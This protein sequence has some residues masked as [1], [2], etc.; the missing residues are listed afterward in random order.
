MTEREG[1]GGKGGS[2]G[3]RR[4]DEGK[5]AKDENVVGEEEAQQ[6]EGKNASIVGEKGG[7]R[8]DYCGEERACR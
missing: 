6:E 7:G 8:K 5:T 3:P 4:G 2:C 1:E